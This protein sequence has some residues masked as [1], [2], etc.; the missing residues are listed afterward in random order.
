MVAPQ[1]SA[2][3]RRI[4][5][6][7]WSLHRTLGNPAIYGVEQCFS[8]PL[9][10]HNQ[11]QCTLLELPA[12]LA[13]FGI[14]TL[15][16]CHFHLPDLDTGY[17]TEL[18]SALQAA[19]IELFS[20]LIDEGD[21]TR[22]EHAERDLAWIE[23]WLEIAGYLGAKR[24]RVIAGKSTSEDALQRS[25]RALNHLAQRAEGSGLRLMTENWFGLLSNAEAVHTLFQQLEER[26]GLCLDFGNWKGPDKYTQLASIAH[27][28]ES[29]HTKAHF[30]TPD[31]LDQPDYVH[32]LN[33]TREAHFVGPYTLIYDGPNDNEWAGLALEREIVQPYL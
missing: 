15:E 18:R 32:C 24:A 6:S 1:T 5:V 33:I 11:G 7:S 17:L 14:T 27:Y 29:C 4:S 22:P 2:S 19:K 3:Q 28:A 10:S 13:A 21:I 26:V 25:V 23:R 8:I 16:I 9:E 20:L 31:Q 30:L 12:R